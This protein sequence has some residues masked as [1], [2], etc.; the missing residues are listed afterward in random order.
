MTQLALDLEFPAPD[1][2]TFWTVCP[3]CGEVLDRFLLG[4]PVGRWTEPVLWGYVA[5]AAHNREI[6][7]EAVGAS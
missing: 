6:H 4:D 1:G 2:V 7:P 5:Q 3:Y